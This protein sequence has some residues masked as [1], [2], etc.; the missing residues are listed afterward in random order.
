MIECDK[1]SFHFNLDDDFSIIDVFARFAADDVI[2]D[3]DAIIT[4]TG[5][6][7]DSD[8][9]PLDIDTDDIFGMYSVKSE[10]Q[11]QKPPLVVIPS[12]EE[13][14]KKLDE[15]MKRSARTRY[16]VFKTIVPTFKKSV[17][18]PASNR[19]IRNRARSAPLKRK[20]PV[21]ATNRQVVK[22]RLSSMI[23]QRRLSSL[24]EDKGF[25]KGLFY[26]NSGIIKTHSAKMAPTTGQSIADF[27][28]C[29][30]R[31]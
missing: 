18:F 26:G 19:A 15:S 9:D 27:L 13:M 2:E 23:V 3:P 8:S 12:M 28:R 31:W 5:G 4:A 20:M 22:R 11:V 29:S 10:D 25:K 24:V 21:K 6:D 17:N 16:I 7:Y 30:K 14:R 1:L